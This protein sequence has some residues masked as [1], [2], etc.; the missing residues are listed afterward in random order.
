MS[1]H[2]YTLEE[3][4]N[5]S[6]GDQQDAV[7]SFVGQNINT[8]STHLVDWVLSIAYDHDDAPFTYEDI[9]NNTPT[10]VVDLQGIGW[11]HLTEEERDDML[12]RYQYL[13]DKAEDVAED[14]L[15]KAKTLQ[16]IA[17]DAADAAFDDS[18][19]AVALNNPD[20]YGSDFDAAF[21]A[22]AA[23]SKAENA[24]ADY[25]ARAE[26]FSEHVYDRFVGICD[27]LESM[28]FDDYPEIYE[29]WD[30][31]SWLLARLGER[32]KCIL[33]NT[34]WGRCTTGQ[35]IMLDHVIVEIYKDTLSKRKE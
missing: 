28:D 5:A 11:V 19:F 6:V 16:E 13:R 23:A 7:Q 25:S 15:S 8:C 34:Y 12:E 26:K 22:T 32:G 10:G 30:C 9:E 18:D 24:A 14:A 27:T 20:F 3:Y 21:A 1:R 35:S 4:E 29:W 2:F 17:D 31:D 33:D